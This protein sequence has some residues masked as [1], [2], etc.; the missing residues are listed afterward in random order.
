MNCKDILFKITQ[1][2]SIPIYTRRFA[3]LFRCIIMIRLNPNN[4]KETMIFADVC[5]S[6]VTIYY[7]RLI[8]IINNTID[9]EKSRSD[10]D[11]LKGIVNLIQHSIKTNKNIIQTRDQ[12][13]EQLSVY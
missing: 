12:I 1:D 13:E 6:I 4:N 5:D 2:E 9:K 7:H 8:Q 10:Y 3:T 11:E